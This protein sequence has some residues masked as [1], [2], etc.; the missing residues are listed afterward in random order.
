MGN[1]IVHIQKINLTRYAL[2]IINSRAVPSTFFHQKNKVNGYNWPFWNPP[3]SMH[4]IS[5]IPDG[6]ARRRQRQRRW[7]VRRLYE[8]AYRRWFYPYWFRA[9][10]P[11]R[12]RRVRSRWRTLT[13]ISGTTGNADGGG[14]A[15]ACPLH[16]SARAKPTLLS[17]GDHHV[18]AP[19]RRR[20]RPCRS[21]PLVHHPGISERNIWPGRAGRKL[22]A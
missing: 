14:V 15:R 4:A 11:G 19:R 21:A 22:L 10:A 1:Y 3:F 12:R 7:S 18:T 9:R 17:R 13:S 5:K 16:P 6:Q 20:P 2:V 8:A